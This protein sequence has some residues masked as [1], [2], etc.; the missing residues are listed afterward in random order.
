MKFGLFAGRLWLKLAL[1]CPLQSVLDIEEKGFQQ[2]ASN[3]IKVPENLW[4]TSNIDPGQIKGAE[5]IKFS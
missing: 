5:P 1:L 4:A 2:K 3:L